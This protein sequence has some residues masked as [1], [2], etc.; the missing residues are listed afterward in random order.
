MRAA[1]WEA[2]IAGHPIPIVRVLQF[3]YPRANRGLREGCAERQRRKRGE[4]TS[5]NERDDTK[6][7][8]DELE[9]TGDELAESGDELAESGG[10][11]AEAGDE[12]AEA[13]DE[14]E[15]TG[16][17]F[18][19][20]GEG[21]DLDARILCPDGACIG[22]V[23]TDGRCR[24]CQTLWPE[25]VDAV[26]PSAENDAKNDSDAVKNAVNNDSDA[27]VTTGNDS[28]SFDPEA[29]ELCPDDTCVGIIGPSGVCGT[30]GARRP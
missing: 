17:E 24:E 16:D 4:T 25:L 5:M 27:F 28:E 29:R 20:S 30:C 12:L 26:P 10:E 18:E 22:L 9:T 3:H 1:Q 23:G 14:L 19:E 7:T 15:E 6:T 8:G 21:F 2:K 11:L 13:G